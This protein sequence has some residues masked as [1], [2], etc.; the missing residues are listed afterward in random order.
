MDNPQAHL[1]NYR[2]G[3]MATNTG[4]DNPLCQLYGYY[5]HHYG[6]VA[7]F[8]RTKSCHSI[9]GLQPQDGASIPGIRRWPQVYL[10][11]IFNR[12][13]VDEIID[14]SQIEAEQTMRALAEREGI[15]CGVSS[16]G[17]YRGVTYFKTS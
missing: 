6:G 17:R 1:R 2:S 11:K 5:G 4:Q 3:N 15:F 16:G 13:R 12:D 9:I 7:L 8:E 14:I 10:P